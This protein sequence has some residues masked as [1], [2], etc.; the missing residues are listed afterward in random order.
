MF[1]FA[2]DQRGEGD[3]PGRN[4]KGLVTYDR[5]TRKD[6]FYFYKANWT[7]TPFVHITSRRWTDRTAAVTTI[8]VY[9]TADS[10]LL[11][12]NGVQVGPPKTSANHIYTWPDVSLSPGTNHV[13]V[14]GTRG[15]TTYTD[16]VT[17]TLR[18]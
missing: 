1:D 18:T 10:V 11:T 16:L 2:S 7:A 8:K 14:F 9:G 15:D 5:R 12:V 13:Q 6:A 4:D 3:T 17:W